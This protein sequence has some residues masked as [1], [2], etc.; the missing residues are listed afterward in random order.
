M[1]YREKLLGL[2][3]KIFNMAGVLVHSLSGNGGN[4]IPWDGKDRFG[5][6]AR[7][8]LYPYVYLVDGVVKQGKLLHIKPQR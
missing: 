1:G 2:E 3:I 6:V 5:N 4:T 7:F 8:G